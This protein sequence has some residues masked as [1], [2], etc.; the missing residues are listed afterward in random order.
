MQ[1]YPQNI[2]DP[3][4]KKKQNY[5]IMA[6]VCFVLY[7]IFI[8]ISLSAPGPTGDY[9]VDSMGSTYYV[10]ENGEEVYG[11]FVEDDGYEDCSDGSDESP[12]EESMS[13]CAGASCCFSI[14]FG[15]SALSVKPSQRVMIIQN[16]QPMVVPQQ[17]TIQ[18]QIPV[19]QT[20]PI[21]QQPQQQQNAIP[22]PPTKE[23]QDSSDWVTKDKN[24]EMARNWEEA[25]KAYEKAGLYAEAGRIRQEHME[26]NQ[27]M[28]Q[29]GQVG[30]TVLNDSVMIAEG[31]KKTCTNCGNQCELDW[32]ICPNCSNPL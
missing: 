9:E 13:V 1:F 25:A 17:I 20:Q 15:I 12:G 24:L 23:E 21:I 3:S 14:I 2:A 16:P 4:K 5:W 19:Q 7:I 22:R 30:N 18:N 29:I 26:K 6:T 11:S 8:A 32:T 31:G 10:C 27:P 28:V